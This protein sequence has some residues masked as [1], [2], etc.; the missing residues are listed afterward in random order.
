INLGYNPMEAQR[1]VQSA[2]SS[3]EKEPPLAEL[4][5]LALKIKKG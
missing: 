5:S 2:V 4:I 1:A 3:N